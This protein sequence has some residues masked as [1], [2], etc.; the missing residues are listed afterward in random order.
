MTTTGSR[1]P[2]TGSRAVEPSS[3]ERGPGSWAARGSEGEI[4]TSPPA[5]EDALRGA[6]GT[7]PCGREVPGRSDSGPRCRSGFRPSGAPSCGR[8]A[9]PGA[10]SPY[11][12]G[13]CEVGLPDSCVAG[14]GADAG[15]NPGLFC[16][17]R[18]SGRTA[19]PPCLR[20]AR[21]GGRCSLAWG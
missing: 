12:R 7:E 19:A 15:G 2:R 5:P 1:V 3:E 11:P 10:R 14:A 4:C 8:R 16:C 20:R 17:C 6:G 21:S 13:G 18:G 9:G